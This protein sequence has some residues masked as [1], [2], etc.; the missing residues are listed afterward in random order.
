MGEITIR[1]RRLHGSQKTVPGY[2][3]N[4][5][6]PQA[7]QAARLSKLY[8]SSG[9]SSRTSFQTVFVMESTQDRLG[10]NLVIN[11]NAM[12][13]SYHGFESNRFHQFVG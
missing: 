10:H 12:S 9:R 13:N 11:R 1:Q 5:L 8:S 6:S 4:C 3:L 7:G 2:F